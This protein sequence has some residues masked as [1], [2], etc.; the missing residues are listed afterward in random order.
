MI[1]IICQNVMRKKWICKHY[2]ED[3]YKMK[4]NE[5]YWEYAGL[6]GS[7]NVIKQ[8]DWNN[9]KKHCIILGNI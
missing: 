4:N 3:H 9:F 5:S 6:M 1:T 8:A 2:S 7:L